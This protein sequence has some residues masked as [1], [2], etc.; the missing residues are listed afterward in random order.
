[1][2]LFDFRV[3]V[4][5]NKSQFKRHYEKYLD[6]NKPFTVSFLKNLPE[7][8][9][10]NLSRIA[11]MIGTNSMSAACYAAA[12]GLPK[13]KTCGSHEVCFL[14]PRRGWMTYC[15]SK[16]AHLDPDNR[17]RMEE[18]V[19]IRH[20]GFGNASPSIASKRNATLIR[21]HGSLDKAYQKISLKAQTTHA[22]KTTEAR[23]LEVEKQNL[24]GFKIKEVI[25]GGRLFKVRGWEHFALEWLVNEKNIPTNK[26]ITECA[27]GK[28][29]FRW[30]GSKVYVPD[31]FVPSTNHK[32]TIIE[33]KSLYTIG[34]L[35][36]DDSTYYDR[37]RQK[38]QAAARD[39]YR[40]KCVLVHQIREGKNGWLDY[41][42][43][44]FPIL[45]TTF[46][47]A[48]RKL[49]TLLQDQ[50]LSLPR[51]IFG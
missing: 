24:S 21:K 45:S 3:A 46:S 27:S 1:M 23:A 6:Q 14:S 5:M 34:L 26:L 44:D 12:Y 38:A 16:C 42:F 9:L 25:V 41:A 35:N 20:G 18:T 48:H 11:D 33:V 8:A 39:G 49:R 43:L 15:S 7:V 32:G 22:R 50:G 28:P 47:R 13:C 19:K 37:V 4:F 29:S 30:S 10:N 51:R 2:N 36:H 17:K 31:I 40:F